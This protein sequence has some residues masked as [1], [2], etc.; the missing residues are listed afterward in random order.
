[1]S[2]QKY[3]IMAFVQC[4]FSIAYDIAILQTKNF[5]KLQKN[6]KSLINQKD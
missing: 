1:M 4:L 6:K 3:Q 5:L 2:F